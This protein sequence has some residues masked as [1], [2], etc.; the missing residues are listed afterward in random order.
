MTKWLIIFLSVVCSFNLYASDT[1]KEKRWADQIVDALID[2]EEVWLST[3]E[4]NAAEF[5]GLYTEASEE[6]AYAAIVIHGSGVHPNWQQVVQPLRVGLTE[7]GWNTLSIQMPILANDAE[8][9]AYA[10]LFDEVSPRI[11]SA[12]EYLKSV[13]KDKIVIVAHSLGASMSAYHLSRSDNDILS[14]VAIGM[15]AGDKDK[16]MD[17]ARSLRKISIPT[18][19]LYGSDDLESVLSTVEKRADAA[20]KSNI[21]HYK[22]LKISEANHF[23]D[24]KEEE[25]LKTVQQWLLPFVK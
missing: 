14:F 19:D 20:K 11:E 24:G 9:E 7:H 2:G 1:A 4:K 8:H 21:K 6:T 15:S 13:D 18:L 5:L 22:Q 10:P 16:R 3:K 17:S 12:I 23:F 25:L